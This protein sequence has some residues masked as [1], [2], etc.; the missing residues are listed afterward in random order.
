MGRGADDDRRERAE[1]VG[2]NDHGEPPPV[3]KVPAAPGE[4]DHVDVTADH[5]AVP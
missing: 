5:G 4:R 3:L 1:V 2:L